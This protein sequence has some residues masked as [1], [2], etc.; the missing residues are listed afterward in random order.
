MKTVY[1][2]VDRSQELSFSVAEFALEDLQ[3]FDVNKVHTAVDFDFD[4]ELTRNL[5]IVHLCVEVR[6]DER[7]VV[8]TH[9][10]I[11]EFFVPKLEE[12]LDDRR[13]LEHASVLEFVYE[14]Y[15]LSRGMIAVRTLGFGIHDFPLPFLPR[16]QMLEKLEVQVQAKR[17]A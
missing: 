16:E 5:L 3:Q 17:K 6:Y 4:K 10:C 2:R 1:S 14:S 12:L 11:Y 13:E 7:M 9:N 15:A 8:L